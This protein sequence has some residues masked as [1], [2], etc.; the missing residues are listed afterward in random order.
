MQRAF[1]QLIKPQLTTLLFKNMVTLAPTTVVP[2]S[3]PSSLLL[4]PQFSLS[5]KSIHHKNVIKSNYEAKGYYVEQLFTGCLA[6]YS[7]YIESGNDCFIIDPLFDTSQYVEL[8]QAR[9]K[10]LKGIFISHYHA[11]YLSGQHELQKKYNCKIYMGPKSIAS[12]VVVTMKDKEQIPLGKIKLECWHTPGHT[13]ESSCLVAFD[14]N[15]RRDT[16]FTGD[17]VFLNEVGRPDL[18]VKTNL[19]ARDLAG[20]LYESIEKL[21]KLNDD[22]RIYPGH[23]SGSACGK[24]IGKGD[25]CS[26]GTQKQNNYGLKAA[27]KEEFI[28]KVLEEM[29]SPPQYFGYNANINKFEPFFHETAAKKVHEDLTPERVR[30]L[31]KQEDVIILDIRGNNALK[32]GIIEGSLCIGFDGAYANWVGTLIDPK[33]R[34]IILGGSEEQF[35][36]SVTRLFRIGYIN[37]IGHINFPIREWEAKGFPVVI[38]Q[39]VN[40][41]VEPGTVI[42]DVRKP[43]EWK[44]DGIVEGS[45]QFELSQLF[46]NVKI[47]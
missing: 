22:I 25:F 37:I 38:P 41:I 36:E 6:I 16:I 11:D 44:N 17:T 30:E 39:F 24:S 19:S 9:G 21:K 43:D 15:G 18:A 7:Y 1:K 42:L 40:E 12:D 5:T 47:L 31:S 20:L 45:V 27:N 32:E 3:R 35:K 2:I 34:L 4:K 8:I 33:Y 23:G 26:L 14:E 28:V 10:T 13:E 46:K 29:P